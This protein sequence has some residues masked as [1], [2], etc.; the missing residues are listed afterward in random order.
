MLIQATSSEMGDVANVIK[1]LDKEISDFVF[2]EPASPV[3]FLAGRRAN[4][5]GASQRKS[6]LIGGNRLKAVRNAGE[7]K[8]EKKWAL[9]SIL[10]KQTLLLTIGTI[11][12]Y[13]RSQLEVDT[14]TVDRLPPFE[15]SAITM[16]GLYSTAR[17]KDL[18]TA[19]GHS[20]RII[21]SQIDSFLE[22]LS[23][24]N[25][26]KQILLLATKGT[27]SLLLLNHIL[28]LEMKARNIRNALRH[29][30]GK[31]LKL[32]MGNLAMLE[33]SDTR[34]TIRMINASTNNTELDSN[35]TPYFLSF[36][37]F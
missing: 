1:I 11:M 33:G 34:L 37:K 31:K 36:K 17:L 15:P 16:E 25:S 4:S 30:K 2:E 7:K 19:I 23:A 8:E 28:I 5:V 14:K 29:L 9:Q 20:L 6:S 21:Y 10:D 12:R 35:F 26:T 32:V 3:P 22:Q 18:Q 27:S 24:E 13:I